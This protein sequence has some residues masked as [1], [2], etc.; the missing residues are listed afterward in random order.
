MVS[1]PF[2]GFAAMTSGG[3]DCSMF[4]GLPVSAVAY[5][6]LCRSLDIAA[7]HRSAEQEGA[8]TVH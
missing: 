2:T 3:V 8:L 7:E 6:L 4:V 5:L 1:A